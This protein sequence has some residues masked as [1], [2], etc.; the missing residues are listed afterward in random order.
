MVS[1]KDAKSEGRTHLLHAGTRKRVS[2]RH[3]LV[4]RLARDERTEEPARKRIACAVRVHDLRRRERADG[5]RLRL[6]RLVRG[7]DDGALRAVR[8]DDRARA[9]RVDL[10]QE[11][12]RA[13]DAREVLGVREP[14]RARPCLGLGFVAD[15][16][17]GVGED[18]A[19]LRAEELRDEWCGDV[20]DEG[21]RIGSRQNTGR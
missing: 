15:D 19:Q 9:R 4:Q 20:Q 21:L 13:R 12:E 6:I 2:G 10:G 3:R 1:E 17:V 8:D 5:E 16:D 18:A 7:D 14:V 11:R